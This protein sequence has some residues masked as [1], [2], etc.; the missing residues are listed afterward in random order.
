MPGPENDLLRRILLV[1]AE[2]TGDE[3]AERVAP[4]KQHGLATD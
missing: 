3:D 1:L 4:S 2:L